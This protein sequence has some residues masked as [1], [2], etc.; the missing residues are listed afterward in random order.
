MM[1]VEEFNR[2]FQNWK[3]ARVATSAK[4]E[5]GNYPHPDEWAWSDDEAVELLESA[6]EIIVNDTTTPVLAPSGWA[7]TLTPEAALEALTDEDEDDDVDDLIVKHSSRFFTNAEE[8][9]LIAAIMHYRNVVLD[10]KPA[11]NEG[12]MAL[13]ATLNGI[14]RDGWVQHS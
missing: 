8:D 13:V 3:T 7:T 1:T 10:R 5:S 11:P 2:R 14:I 12:D 9:A 4:E 6:A